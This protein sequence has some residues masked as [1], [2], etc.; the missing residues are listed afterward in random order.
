M[1]SLIRNACLTI[2]LAA[3]L[4]GIT[5]SAFGNAAPAGGASEAVPGRINIGG[6]NSGPTVVGLDNR[7]RLVFNVFDATAANIVSANLW[8]L[9]SGGNILSVATPSLPIS[10]PAD[11]YTTVLVQGQRDGNT[12][13]A[14]LFPAFGTTNNVLAVWTY[15]LAGQVIASAIYGPYTDTIIEDADWQQSTGK[16]LVKWASRATPISDASYSAWSINEVG[17]VD[18][19]AGPFGPFTNTIVSKVLLLNDG[20]QHWVWDTNNGNS[21][22]TTAFWVVSPGGQVR[23]AQQFGPF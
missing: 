16:L 15:N 7:T 11:I 12:T 17:G 2:G 19:A 18:T 3:T 22:H 4:G 6:V 13:V 5:P 1:K 23:L 20:T 9:G 21:T 10:G 14:F 8:I